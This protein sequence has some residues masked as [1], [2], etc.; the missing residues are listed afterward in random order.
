MDNIV[1]IRYIDA[2][3]YTRSEKLNFTDFTTHIAIGNLVAVSN[4]HVTLSF[5]EKNKIPEKGLLIPKTALI[6]EKEKYVSKR[7]KFNFSNLNT[8]SDISIF[9]NDLVYFQN[10]GIPDQCTP[11]YSEGKLF[12]LTP[13]AIILRESNTIKIKEKGV[14]MHPDRHTSFVVIPKSFITSI[15][16]YGKKP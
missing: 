6:F 14:S 9:W 2:I 8:G 13:N 11:M 3:Y 15:E 4:D 12:S 10:S 1:A 5:V 16:F 7:D